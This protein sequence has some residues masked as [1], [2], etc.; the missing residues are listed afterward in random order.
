MPNAIRFARIIASLSSSNGLASKDAPRWAA[1]GQIRAI[2]CAF[3]YDIYPSIGARLI[4]DKESRT[5]G[6]RAASPCDS[7]TARAV[8]DFC[9]L[10]LW[11]K[12]AQPWPGKQRAPDW[13]LGRETTR[14]GANAHLPEDLGQRESII[15]SVDRLQALPR[16]PKAHRFTAPV[17]W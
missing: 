3:V 1:Q 11:D 15:A 2:T 7:T 9:G 17:G 12:P 10:A 6:G 16:A 8:I 5:A 14:P 13:A 4:N